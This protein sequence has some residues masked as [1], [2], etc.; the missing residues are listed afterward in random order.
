MNTRPNPY[1]PSIPRAAAGLVAA[2]MSAVTMG[3]LVALPATVEAGDGE[4]LAWPTVVAAGPVCVDAGSAGTASAATAPS[5]PDAGVRTASPAPGPAPAR[6]RA[7]GD[8]RRRSGE[9]RRIVS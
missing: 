2:A 8:P 1:Q 5:A 4:P 7:A 3:A 9:I 6:A